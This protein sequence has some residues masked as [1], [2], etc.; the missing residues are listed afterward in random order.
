MVL[1]LFEDECMQHVK[2]VLDM[3]THLGFIIHPEKCALTPSTTFVYL[4]NVWNTTLWRVG[5]K[6]K[7]ETSIRSLASD[8]LTK[9]MAAVRKFSRLL[10]KIRSTADALP[11]ARADVEL[12]HLI[13]PLYA[14][15]RRITATN[16]HL[17]LKLG[18]NWN[19]GQAF[20]LVRAR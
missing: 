5:I 3:L 8:I 20:L 11:L 19:I 6:E 1:A 18:K 2:I 16:F 12:W 15:S 13:F 14:R 7:R 17:Q 4:G 10:G 9:D